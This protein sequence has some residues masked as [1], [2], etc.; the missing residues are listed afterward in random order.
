MNAFNRKV[1]MVHGIKQR[2][3]ELNDHW[4][5]PPLIAMGKDVESLNCKKV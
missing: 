4:R 2:K 5:N 3:G 1:Q